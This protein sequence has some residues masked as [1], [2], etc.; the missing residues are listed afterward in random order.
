[1][2]I[3]KPVRRFFSLDYREYQGR[4]K[5]MEKTLPPGSPPLTGKAKEPVGPN[6]FAT[7]PPARQKDATPDYPVQYQ[8]P[9]EAKQVGWWFRKKEVFRPTGQGAI[10]TTGPGLLPPEHRIP[11]RFDYSTIPDLRM[12]PKADEQMPP[13]R[14]LVPGH[15]VGG[16]PAN[17]GTGGPTLPRMRQGS[18]SVEEERPMPLARPPEQRRNPSLDSLGLPRID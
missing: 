9:V 16:L 1:M 17:P 18:F 11:G 12:I 4:L 13:V 15:G 14:T 3:P 8:I 7:L 5:S 10:L 2:R 6:A